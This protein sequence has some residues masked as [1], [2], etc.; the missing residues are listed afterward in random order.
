MAAMKSKVPRK[1]H[2]LTKMKSDSELPIND[3]MI[4]VSLHKKVLLADHNH[5]LVPT[6]AESEGSSEVS[7]VERVTLPPRYTLPPGQMS[8]GDIGHEARE[9]DLDVAIRWLR[10]EIVSIYV[11]YL[12]FSEIR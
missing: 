3:S 8:N 9:A 4:D 6:D 1:P 2:A 11:L 10:Q 12:K 7:E 5:N